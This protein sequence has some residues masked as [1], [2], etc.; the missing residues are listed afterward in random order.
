MNNVYYALFS[1]LHFYLSC[2][3]SELDYD[4]RRL[5]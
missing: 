3:E 4:E 1:F 2:S 5:D